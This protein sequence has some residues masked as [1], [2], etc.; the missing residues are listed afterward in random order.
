M[1]EI[2]YIPYETAEDL[3]KFLYDNYYSTENLIP[4]TTATGYL[5]SNIF[6]LSQ[7]TGITQ[8]SISMINYNLPYFNP[9]YSE[10]VWKCYLNSMDDCF[11]FFG[12]K[13]TLAEP[14][15]NMIESHAG[16]MINAGKLYASVAD[17]FTQ[18]KV[19]IIGIDATRV[20][21]YK[22]EYNKFFI[23]PLP[24]VEEA[25]GLPEIFS[26]ERV[27]KMITAL[28]NFSPINQV[29]YIVQYIKNFVGAD[30]I[31]KFN[32]FIYREVYAD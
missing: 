7:E 24:V 27:W 9:I 5:R 3:N 6:E 28:T 32:R 10:A 13:E 20:Q 14:T 18:Q 12:F 15:Y 23:K 11:A 21:E 17:G 25:L 4:T 31:I 19:E 30:K 29:H 8:N 1:P 22:I 26:V 2:N 16:F